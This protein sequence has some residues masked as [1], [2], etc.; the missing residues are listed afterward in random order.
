MPPL[1]RHQLMYL[2]GAGWQTVLG[3]SWDAEALACLQHWAAHRLPLVVTRQPLQPEVIGRHVTLGLSAPPAWGRRLLSLQLPPAALGWIDEFPFAAEVVKQVPGATRRKVRSLIGALERRGIRTRTY[4][5][6][7]WQCLTGLE[8]V[9][10]CSDLDLWFAVESTAQADEAVEQLLACVPPQLR[11]DGEL[12][13][14]DGAA[15]AWREWAAWRTGLTRG[16]LV[17]RL[18]SVGVEQGPFG[19]PVLPLAAES[20]A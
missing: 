4:G 19:A 15:V 11:L 18:R 14:P 6:Y 17:K 20:V 3:R 2:S 16:V 9:H 12:V 7:G 10:G 5:S 8:Y 13:F 1:R